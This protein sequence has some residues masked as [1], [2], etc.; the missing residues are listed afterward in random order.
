LFVIADVDDGRQRR[1]VMSHER[2]S[3]NK[4][5]SFCAILVL[6]LTSFIFVVCLFH[7]FIVFIHK[8]SYSCSAH[9]TES[10]RLTLIFLAA[11]FECFRHQ[12][13]LSSRIFNSIKGISSRSLKI[14]FYVHVINISFWLII[15]RHQSLETVNF[16]KF[17]SLTA[18][19]A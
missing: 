17:S 16:L 10:T 12:K 14:I 19:F 13:N 11:F 7:S 1:I 15:S 6:S 5:V 3:H 2:S 9:W 18:L 8:K 4:I